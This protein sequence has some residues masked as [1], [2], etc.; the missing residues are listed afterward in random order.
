M[1]S[2]PKDEP[3]VLKMAH[4]PDKC[5]SWKFSDISLKDVYSGGFTNCLIN[6]KLSGMGLVEVSVITTEKQRFF[7]IAF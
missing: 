1:S 2:A 7:L 4:P 5:F 3:K 6:F